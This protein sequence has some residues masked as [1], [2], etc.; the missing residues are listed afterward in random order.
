[1]SRPSTE[2]FFPYRFDARFAPVW[3]PL[4]ARPGRD[5]VT[6]TP[7]RVRATMGWFA[8]ETPRAN[9]VGGHLTEGY[10]WWKAI[11]VRLSAADD[12]LTFGTNTDRGVCIHFREP[13]PPVL[14]PR[15]HSAVTV[16]VDD[17]VGLLRA[18]GETSIADSDPGSASP[19]T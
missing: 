7:D 1:M 13:V 3:L 9:V 10:R 11:G 19:A 15:R 4:G 6:V 5:G 17:C 12:G 14:G 16:T 8:L 18:I 2:Q